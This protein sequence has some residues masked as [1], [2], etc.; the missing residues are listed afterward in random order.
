MFRVIT[1][2]HNKMEEINLKGQKDFEK[3]TIFFNK[4]INFDSYLITNVVKL[5]GL[6]LKFKMNSDENLLEYESKF[7]PGIFNP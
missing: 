7:I 1:K 3:M 4:A 2:N 6:S 5:V